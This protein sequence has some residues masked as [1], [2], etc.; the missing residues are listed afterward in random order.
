MALPATVEEDLIRPQTIDD[1]PVIDL[2]GLSV[3]FG[4]RQILKNLRGDLRG[5]AIGLLGPNGAGKTT[6]IHTLL[7]FH[8]PNGGTAHIFGHDIIDDAKKI[9]ALIGYMPERDSF[10]AKMTAVHF[11]RLMAELSGLPSDAALER[12]HEALFY[13]GLGEA[14]YRKLETYS[15]GMKQLAKL[16]QAIVHGP[17]LIF[18]DEPTNGLDPPARLRMI[19][20]IREIRDSGQA[21]IVLSSHL[22][23]DVEECCDE[24]LILRDGQIAVYCNLE[25]ERKSNRKFLMLET[26]G[27]QKRFVEA[28]AK[29]GCEYAISSDSRLKVVLQDGIEVRDLYR[30]AA[31][32]NVQLRRLSY[33]RDSLEDIFLKAMENGY[34][35]L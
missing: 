10:I 2:H 25:E 26:R 33:K 15:L 9:R 17:K 11:V 5:K 24:I 22:L 31:E 19:K 34:G 20:L 13:V 29:L 12:A 3:A 30:L 35:G 6:L 18:L 7:G 23:V 4:R 32:T 8:Q 27:D 16:A 1:P 14:R 21:N 28:M